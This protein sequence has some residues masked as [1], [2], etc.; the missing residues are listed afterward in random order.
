MVSMNQL[1]NQ[2]PISVF[3]N[4]SHDESS[5]QSFQ[6]Q[7]QPIPLMNVSSSQEFNEG[8]IPIRNEG[9]YTERIGT[10]VLQSESASP[11]VQAITSS[12]YDA[13]GYPKK[14][15]NELSE[16]TSRDSF[17]NPGV[18]LKMPNGQ[19]QM[20]PVG[21]EQQPSQIFPE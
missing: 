19:T 20:E 12:R 1:F 21:M 13:H 6:M 10:N 4:G 9:Q 17:V 2:K 3:N 14:Q 11:Y 15:I 5:R 8:Y 7:P 18:Y 16:M